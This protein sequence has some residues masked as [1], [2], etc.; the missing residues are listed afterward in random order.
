M[1]TKNLLIV[2]ALF[3]ALNANAKMYGVFYGKNG[4]NLCCPQND[5][6]DLADLY[7]KNGGQVIP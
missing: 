4:D 1:F 7:R 5:V 3:F 2:F 6:T